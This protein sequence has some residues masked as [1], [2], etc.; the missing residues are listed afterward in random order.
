MPCFTKRYRRLRK[1]GL[2][3]LTVARRH[4]PHAQR[5][6]QQAPRTL[7]IP[8]K[9]RGRPSLG[10]THPNAYALRRGVELPRNAEAQTS[11]GLYCL[12]KGRLQPSIR[13][14]YV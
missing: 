3:E 2:A 10:V 5:A 12:R 8:G 1:N 11:D 9:A 13:E 4:S 7:R 6:Q 14:R